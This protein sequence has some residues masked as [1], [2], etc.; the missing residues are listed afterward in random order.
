[1]APHKPGAHQVRPNKPYR[2]KDEC[3]GESQK[4]RSD[5]LNDQG[6]GLENIRA[7]KKCS[8]SSKRRQPFARARP[9]EARESAPAEHTKN[10]KGTRHDFGGS[11]DKVTAK[12]TAKKCIEPD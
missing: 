1:M 6:I 9:P 8:K 4:I 7:Q 12:Y 3:V 11:C 5:A 2:A 10:D